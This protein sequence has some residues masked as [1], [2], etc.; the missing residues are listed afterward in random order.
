VNLLD[1]ILEEGN[2]PDLTPMID[3]VFLLLI[4][5]MVTAAFVGPARFTVHLPEAVHGEMFRPERADIAVSAEGKVALG[6]KVV[7]LDELAEELER[8]RPRR[9]VIRADG[10]APHG[11]VLD[12]LEAVGRAGVREVYM[13]VR[14]KG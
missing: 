10:D 1:D 2:S 6:G 8:R 14:R 9:V 3:C 11:A 5:F 7:T 12:V 4:F 13:A